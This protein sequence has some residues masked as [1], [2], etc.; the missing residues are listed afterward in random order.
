MVCCFPGWLIKSTKE[1]T[2][3]P[4]TPTKT[5]KS[6]AVTTTTQKKSTTMADIKSDSKA[7]SAMDSTAAKV[8]GAEEE[9]EA[10]ETMVV[11]VHSGPNFHS[12]A[13]PEGYN[14]KFALVSSEPA[15]EGG[16]GEGPNPMEYLIMSLPVC[17]HE[18]AGVVAASLGITPESGWSAVKWTCEFDVNLSGYMG[19]APNTLSAKEIFQHVFIGVQPVADPNSV[20]ELT[21]EQLQDLKKVVESTCPIHRLLVAAGIDFTTVWQPTGVAFPINMTPEDPREFVERMGV[22]V[23]S[24]GFHSEVTVNDDANHL[25]TLA[26]PVE[27]GGSGEGPNPMEALITSLAVCEF[28]Q[29]LVIAMDLGVTNW[30]MDMKSSFLINLDGYMDKPGKR[31]MDAKDVFK[32]VMTTAKITTDAD[33]DTIDKIWNMQHERCPVVRLFIDAGI[34]VQGDWKKLA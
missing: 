34:D 13:V 8:E 17:M 28:E 10:L 31:N 25:V 7:P 33:Q 21:Y 6:P 14:G 9:G 15:H 4:S 18:E 22:T 24:K 11:D 20:R 12:V 1:E 5:T 26:E 27:D 3:S 23:Q 16:S 19:E 2:A 30:E 29:S 32:S